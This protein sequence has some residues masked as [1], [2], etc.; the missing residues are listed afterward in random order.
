MVVV[1]GSTVKRRDMSPV[2]Q[3]SVNDTISARADGFG[4]TSRAMAALRRRR[5]I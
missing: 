5:A 1:A 4:R 2:M 3:G